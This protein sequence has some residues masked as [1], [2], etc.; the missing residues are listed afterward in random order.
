MTEHRQFIFQSSIIVD[1]NRGKTCAD[2][3]ELF[4]LKKRIE[5]FSKL[6][7]RADLDQVSFEM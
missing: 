2:F 7:C 1:Q 6:E 5:T 4:Y 3:H